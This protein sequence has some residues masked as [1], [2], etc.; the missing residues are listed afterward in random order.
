MA[1]HVGMGGLARA[2]PIAHPWASVSTPSSFS[3]RYLRERHLVAATP[4]D[5]GLF[6]VLAP[7]DGVTDWV[8]RELASSLGGVSQCVTEF[9]RVTDR[10]PPA[11]V[12]LRDCPELTRGGVTSSGV[13]VFV[14]ILGGDPHAMAQAGKLAA[15]L[16]APGIDINF[17]CPAKRV[18]NHDGGA[19]ILRCPERAEHI[20]RAVRDAV[21]SEIPVTV[22]VRVGWSDADAMVE[23][24]QAVERGGASWLTVHGRTKSQMYA[25]PVD[26]QAIGRA[27]AAISIPVVANGDLVSEASLLACS[28]QSGASAFMVGRGALARPFVFRELRG[29]PVSE[30]NVGYLAAYAGV[31]VRYA[32]LM[33]S[34]GFTP[35]GTLRRLKQWLSLARTFAPEILPLF[36]RIKLQSELASALRALEPEIADA[37]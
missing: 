19:S 23:I 9:V 1:G 15:Q 12:F 35:E 34:G 7:M 26:Y 10:A 30:P 11:R 37:A 24:A 25:P 21:P 2:T 14:Q 28:E 16:G 36:E 31:L 32:E 3:E 8:H 29:E 22:K 17:G 27:R 13:R 20:T 5:A 4:H 33:T 6:L 18:N